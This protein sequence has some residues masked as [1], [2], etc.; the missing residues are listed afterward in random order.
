[1]H[2]IRRPGGSLR[3]RIEAPQAL[4]RVAD[5]LDANRLGVGRRK[6]IDDAATHGKGAVLV[7]RILARETSVHEQVRESLRL[8]LRPWTELDRCPQQALTRTHARQQRR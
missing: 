6:Y 1:M 8:D 2:L 3:R 7:H 4:D 5:E